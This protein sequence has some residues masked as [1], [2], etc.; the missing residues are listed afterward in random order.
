MNHR[1]SLT[2]LALLALVAAALPQPVAAAANFD[3]TTIVTDTADDFAGDGSLD[4]VAVHIAERYRYNVEERRGDDTIAVRFQMRS[5]DDL[6][7]GSAIKVELTFMAGGQAKKVAGGVA[8]AFAGQAGCVKSANDI[9]GKTVF[10]ATSITVIVAKAALGL[11]DGTSL[12]GIYAISYLVSAAQDVGEDVAPH[13]NQNAPQSAPPTSGMLSHV[14]VGNFPSV[15]VTPITPLEQFSVGGQEIKYQ[16]AFASHPMLR[17]ENLRVRFTMPQGWT[18]SPSQGRTGADPEGQLTAAND[19]VPRDFSFSLSATGI[20]EEGDVV[21][22]LMQVISDRGGLVNVTTLTTVSGAKIPAPN[23]TI[24]L[25]T[26][27][28]FETGSQER[29]LSVANLSGPLSN[30]RFALEVTKPG[31]RATYD[32]EALGNGTF[33]ATVNFK[34]EGSHTVDGYISSLRP[35]PHQQFVVQV[36][37][38][39][40]APGPGVPL[41][42]VVVGL[43]VLALRRRS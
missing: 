25:L 6:K 39:G 19:G 13:P 43:A 22:V 11:T 41:F 33:K 5:V 23:P 15:T 36:E 16:F 4:I 8:N 20:A 35:S 37:D 29:R 12:T 10:D 34:S 27:G 21:P 38:G 14:L 17:D 18:V 40:L 28:P 31:Q 7:C 32:A 42:L 9:T 30:I 2:L 1:T 26:P 3:E 24:G